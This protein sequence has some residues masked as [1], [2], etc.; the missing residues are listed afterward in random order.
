MQQLDLIRHVA[1]ISC[2]V[3]FAGTSL[4]QEGIPKQ[5]RPIR[6]ISGDLNKDGVDE[7]IVV[8]NM[9]ETEDDVN[10]INREIIIFRNENEKWISW[11][12]STKAIGN[13]KDGGMMG[14][15]FEDIEIKNGVLI[16]SHSG[17]SSWKWSHQ[18]KYRFQNGRFELIGYSSNSGKLCEYWQ[19]F[20][21]NIVIGKIIVT[22]EYERCDD[23]EGPQVVY[24]K[25][26]ET[27]SHKLKKQVFLENRKD[28]EIKIISPRYKHELYL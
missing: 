3:F 14:D 6:E 10:G 23:D 28:V 24:K 2:L 17:G 16:I 27:F 12:R 22:K 7:R 21:F 8:Y 18:D 15:P 26:N 13:S 25:E 1:I 11:H 20:D 4:A 5:Y 19:D 9:K